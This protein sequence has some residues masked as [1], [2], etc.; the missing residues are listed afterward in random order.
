MSEVDSMSVR[1]FLRNRMGVIDTVY[2]QHEAGML[3]GRFYC[4]CGYQCQESEWLLHVAD[5]I[6]DAIQGP[7]V[8]E[9]P[10]E[11]PA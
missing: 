5:K 11:V 1:M 8:V 4:H 3:N 7:S 2:L 10:F 6:A 9:L